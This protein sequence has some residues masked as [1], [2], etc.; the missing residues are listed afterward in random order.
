MSNLTRIYFSFLRISF[1]PNHSN[2]FES[3]NSVVTFSTT[4]FPEL[5]CTFQQFSLENTLDFPNNKIFFLGQNGYCSNPSQPILPI[6]T[7]LRHP[8]I[9]FQDAMRGLR[10]CPDPSFFVACSGVLPS[11][12]SENFPESVTNLISVHEQETYLSFLNILPSVCDKIF[13]LSFKIQ[14][15]FQPTPV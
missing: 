3:L 10:D 1:Q 8:Q 13:L 7:A 5:M 14:F 4:S 11:I 6:A 12:S 2:F 9:I 15:Y